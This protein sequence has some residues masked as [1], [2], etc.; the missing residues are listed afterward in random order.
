MPAIHQK[1]PKK[2]RY[3]GVFVLSL[4]VAAGG[5]AAL[6]YVN[7]W[8]APAQAKKLQNPVTA[9]PEV[10]ASGRKIYA[11]HCGKCHGE[12]GNG[13]GPKAPELSILPQDFTDAHA[14]SGIT[15]GEFRRGSW[16]M[17]FLYQI[18]GVAKTDQTLRIQFRNEAGPVEVKFVV[19]RLQTTFAHPGTNGKDL[20]DLARAAAAELFC[21]GFPPPDSAPP[22]P[23][24]PGPP[25]PAAVKTIAD[26]LSGVEDEALKDALARLGAAIKR[27]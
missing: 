12:S 26:T 23:P 4:I 10:I 6:Y 21:H 25:D 15:D 8:S 5:V 13:R 11:E 3:L 20:K 27:N 9:N 22:H 19:R 16:H 1:D 14:M 17:D 2:P 24:P 18:G 7:N